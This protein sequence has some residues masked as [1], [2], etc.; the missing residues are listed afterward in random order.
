MRTDD[1][2]KHFGTVL[3]LAEA[4]GVTRHAIYQWGEYVPALRQY[5]LQEL[6]G[7][8]LKRVEADRL[9]KRA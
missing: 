3:A 6:T 5:E 1:A 8:V 4:L 7:G 2:I 9:E